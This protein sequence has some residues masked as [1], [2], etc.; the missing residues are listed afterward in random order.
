MSGLSIRFSNKLFAVL[1]QGSLVTKR[2]GLLLNNPHSLIIKRDK[3]LINS[4]SFK[5]NFSFG[6]LVPLARATKNIIETKNNNLIIIPASD[7][8]GSPVAASKKKVLPY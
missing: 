4:L 1:Y 6:V 8:G 2:A 5:I 3:G 7:W